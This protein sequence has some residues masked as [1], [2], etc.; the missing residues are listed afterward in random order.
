MMNNEEKELLEFIS[1]FQENYNFK[2][3]S[4][5]LKLVIK[6]AENAN[7]KVDSAMRTTLA[8]LMKQNNL[9]PQSTVKLY[10]DI[11]AKNNSSNFVDELIDATVKKVEPQLDDAVAIT[12][13]EIAALFLEKFNTPNIATQV[14]D[15]TNQYAERIDGSLANRKQALNQRFNKLLNQRQPQ[16]VENDLLA[17]KRLIKSSNNVKALNSQVI[18]LSPQK[19]A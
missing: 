11:Q 3:S 16:S 1:W 19:E 2:I 8:A 18:R 9:T 10:L 12:K 14:D 15:F 6:A 5:E 7:L 17:G 13:A 4:Y